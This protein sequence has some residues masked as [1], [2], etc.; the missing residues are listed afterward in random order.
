MQKEESRQQDHK[1]LAV[2]D[3]YSVFGARIIQCVRYF[4]GDFLV[5][6]EITKIG[7]GPD[8]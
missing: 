8:V 2:H 7:F 4:L 6:L 1:Q 5:K 3:P